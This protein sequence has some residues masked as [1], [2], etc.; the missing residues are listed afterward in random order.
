MFEPDENITEDDMN[1]VCNSVVVIFP[2]TLIFPLKI[3][4]PLTIKK[5]STVTPVFTT[6]PLFGEIVAVAEP[7]FILSISPI[8]AADILNN[9]LPSPLNKDAVIEDDT[10]NDPVI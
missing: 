5:L 6:N 1:V 9:P 4:L 7:D 8:D 3:P 10:A 2:A